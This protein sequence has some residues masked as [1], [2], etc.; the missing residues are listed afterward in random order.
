MLEIT[1]DCNSAP[2]L[3][4]IFNSSNRSN[5]GIYTERIKILRRNES[6]NE[7]SS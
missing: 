3:D 1:V 7:G 2:N 5:P 6:N 4:R